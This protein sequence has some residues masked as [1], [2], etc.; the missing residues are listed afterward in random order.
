M[1]M[2]TQP[3]DAAQS[4][5]AGA[6]A[7]DPTFEKAANQA[8]QALA[9]MYKACHKA[10]P[11][12]PLCDA[13][14]QMQKAIGEIEVQYQ[15]QAGGG[16]PPM[17]PSQMAPE[18]PDAENPADMAAEPGGEPPQE[19]GPPPFNPDQAAQDAAAAFAKR[20]KAV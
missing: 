5:D 14:G 4:P 3:P 1:S 9:L 20:R 6:S 7:G 2:P 12:S 11:D 13:L 18:A 15:Q 10:Y 19:A 17:D 8:T 16:Q